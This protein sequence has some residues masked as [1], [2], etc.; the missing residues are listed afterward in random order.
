[1]KD[2]FLGLLKFLVILAIL[3]VVGLFLMYK[4]TKS[5]SEGVNEMHNPKNYAISIKDFVRYTLAEAHPEFANYGYYDSELKIKTNSKIRQLADKEDDPEKASYKIALETL[6]KNGTD[7]E[8]RYAGNLLKTYNALKIDLTPY[9]VDE[10]YDF[11]WHFTEKNSRVRFTVSLGLLSYYDADSWD[12]D[13]YTE[14]LETGVFEAAPDVSYIKPE[15]DDSYIE[16]EDEDL[17]RGDL[18]ED[19][20]A[21]PVRELIH[22]R[23]CDQYNG[24]YT[25]DK[26]MS[27]AFYSVFQKAQQVDDSEVG[28]PDWDYWYKYYGDVKAQLSSVMVDKETESSAIAHIALYYPERHNNECIFI[29][30]PMVYENGNWFVDDIICYEDNTRHSLKETANKKINQ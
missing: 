26:I 13:R 27:K 29:D 6:S 17:G 5:V 4:C 14:Y 24:W 25:N 12:L 10:E 15:D 19:I 30:L 21:D 28:W 1:M 3:G 9:K 22:A 11:K 8:K 23:I 20:D 7:F 16:P 18:C 2:F